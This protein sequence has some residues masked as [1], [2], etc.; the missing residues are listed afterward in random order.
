M[1]VA[2]LRGVEFSEDFDEF[3]SPKSPF[4]RS[5][6]DGILTEVANAFG[7]EISWNDPPS[8][9]SYFAALEDGTIESMIFSEL[10][11]P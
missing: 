11:R 1:V 2:Q 9:D 10:E 8:E 6:M 7:L 4:F 3:M 5:T